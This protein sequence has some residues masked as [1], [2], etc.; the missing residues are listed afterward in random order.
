MSECDPEKKSAAPSSTGEK[1]PRPYSPPMAVPLG[2]I[3]S[4]HAS[5][6]AGQSA[7]SV[8]AESCT[9]GDGVGGGAYCCA[10]TKASSNTQCATGTNAIGVCTGAGNTPGG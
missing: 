1:S 7:G 10:G 6:M 9:V 4:S 8:G 2:P 3:V 5:C